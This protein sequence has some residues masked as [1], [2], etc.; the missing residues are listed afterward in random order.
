[1][2]AS[3]SSGVSILG[4]WKMAATSMN[5][6]SPT[7]SEVFLSAGVGGWHRWLRVLSFP[8]HKSLHPIHVTM[9][10]ERQVQALY[11]FHAQPNSGE[12]TILTG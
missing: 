10:G 7:A 2:L 9:N 3:C 8:R 6:W 1:M 5:S 11:D 12:L 4:R